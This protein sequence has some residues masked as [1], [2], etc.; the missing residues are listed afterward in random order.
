MSLCIM[1]TTVGEV[2]NMFRGKI[3]ITKIVFFPRFGV[4]SCCME[5]HCYFFFL[6]RC[7]WLR[8]KV[9]KNQ[10]D[11][12]IATDPHIERSIRLLLCFP[13]LLSGF[14][15]AKFLFSIQFQINSS[16]LITYFNSYRKSA[17]RYVSVLV[18]TLV[19]DVSNKFRCENHITVIVFFLDL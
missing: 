16:D 3:H 18:G 9:S 15:H 4:I 12:P 2:S 14:S 13:I 6:L 5:H 11:E 1:G 17:M 7:I 8:I 19:G 10:I